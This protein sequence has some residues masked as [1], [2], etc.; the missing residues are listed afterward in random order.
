MSLNTYAVVGI[1]LRNNTPMTTL[2]KV[3]VECTCILCIPPGY[4]TD[5]GDEPDRKIPS[6][7]EHLLISKKILEKH[8]IKMV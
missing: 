6:K 3:W 5:V 8:T 7:H 2:T 1:H 4:G